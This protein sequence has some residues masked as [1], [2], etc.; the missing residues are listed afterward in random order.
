MV[1]WHCCDDVHQ[2][3]HRRHA[4]PRH[5]RAV[6]S[7][8][9][10]AGRHGHRDA[11][12][13]GETACTSSRRWSSSCSRS[14][15]RPFGTPATASNGRW[16]SHQRRRRHSQRDTATRE[17]AP[18]HTVHLSC[19][20]MQRCGEMNTTRVS[21]W[22]SQTVATYTDAAAG[23]QRGVRAAAAAARCG[24]R[25]STRLRTTSPT[26]CT[27]ASFLDAPSDGRALIRVA[28]VLLTSSLV[29]PSVCV[30]TVEK[31]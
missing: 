5:V 20:S 3:R 21:R 16:W 25:T 15:S 2:L 18:P 22:P 14:R 30:G 6:Q 11:P 4:T 27:C 24:A 13:A 26:H 17:R 10:T 9:G 29:L 1:L 23:K 8:H 31:I 19:V 28:R 7:R 12:S